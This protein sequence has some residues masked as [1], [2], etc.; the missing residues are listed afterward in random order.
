M[1]KKIVRVR[2][3]VY[4]TDS[5]GNT[6]VFKVKLNKKNG[7]EY[8]VTGVKKVKNYLDRMRVSNSKSKP[9]SLKKSTRS[10]KSRRRRLSRRSFGMSL[11]ESITQNYIG[12]D[13]KQFN[14]HM[15]GINKNDLSNFYVG[16]A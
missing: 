10:S 2:N 9:K 15:G 5:R 12:M 1:S 6:K 13:A 14:N 3:E 11:G 8:Y 7:R 4:I 16:G